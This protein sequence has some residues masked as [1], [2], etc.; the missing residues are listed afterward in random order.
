MMDETR[1]MHMVQ[2]C[3]V[4]WWRCGGLLLI[5][6]LLIAT[7]GCDLAL[8]SLQESQDALQPEAVVA[9][10]ITDFN[11]ALQD[12]NI[13][14]R[15]T[16]Q[17][18][19][20]RLANYFA[21]AE[22]AVQQSTLGFMLANFAGGLENLAENQR[23]V[24]EISYANLETVEQSEHQ[25]QVAIVEGELLLRRMRVEPNGAIILQ[26]TQ[27]YPLSHVLG[28]YSDMLPVVWVSGQWFLTEG[29][30]KG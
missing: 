23:L 16:R 5:F 20:I 25:A 7:S 22:R 30:V 28:M 1:H 29:D 3:G 10:F 12:P 9:A 4:M 15:E 21:P 2:R 13:Q 14:Q 17:A 19:A 26:D 27:E 24:I 6:S 18:W 11:S 8:G